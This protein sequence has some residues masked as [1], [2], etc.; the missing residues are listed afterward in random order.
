MMRVIVIGAGIMGLS[1]AWALTRAGH[2]VT[3]VEQSATVPNPLGSSADQHRLIRYPYGAMAGYTRMVAE[4]YPA[5]ERLWA[6]LGQRLYVETGTLAIGPAGQ[7]WI[8]ESAAALE[9]AGVPF[10]WLEPAELACRYPLL[11]ADGLGPALFQASGGIL[12]ADRIVAALAARSTIVHAR[13][14]A[15]DPDSAAV[16]LADG[17]RLT[18]DRLVV[19]AG[20]WVRRLLPHLPVTPSRQVV[21]YLGGEVVPWQDMPMVLGIAP[22]S[23]IYLVPPA[24]GTGLKIGD[25]SFTL[26]GDPDHDREATT[27]EAAEI[28]A[29]CSERLAHPDSLHPI[30]A[31]TCF[32][33]VA[34]EEH[35]IVEPLGGHTWVMSG[36]S[37]HGF[38]FGPVLGEAVAAA[39]DGRR[40]AAEVTRRAAGYFA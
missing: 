25:H 4:A 9:T 31:K 21:V 11:R 29:R 33:D 35:F 5:W 19:A 36:F 2:E 8:D 15:I 7:P 22:A 39:L 10:S 26:T 32:Y 40:D 18:A 34:C 37:G 30:A 1:T 24:G 27:A 14:T 38:K 28:F 23:G 17:T 12:L 6:E 20:P 13:A 16:A 3:V